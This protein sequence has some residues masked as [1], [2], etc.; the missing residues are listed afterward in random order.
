MADFSTAYLNTYG[1]NPPINGVHLHLYNNTAMRLDWCRLRNKLDE[2]RSWQQ[3]QG[4]LVNRPIIV[5]EYGVL[6]SS[7]KYPGDKAKITGN[8]APGCECD[9]MAGLFDVFQRRSWVQYHLWWATYSDRGTSAPGETWDNAN[10]FTDSNGSQVTNPVGL[11]Y[12]ALS[13]R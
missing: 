8:C 4:W 10:I 6:S 7:S 2:F 11:R 3:G 9:F 1:Q 5:S 13:G 12:M